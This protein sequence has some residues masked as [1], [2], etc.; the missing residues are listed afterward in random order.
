MKRCATAV[1][2]TLA[3]VSCAT[4]RLPDYSEIS[5]Q[6]TD[7]PFW[8]RVRVSNTLAIQYTVGYQH[9]PVR[10]RAV[11]TSREADAALVAALRQ[12]LEDDSVDVEALRALL[13]EDATR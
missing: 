11:P 3:C 9:N 1:A 12:L 2:L 4:P 6:F 13:R 10:V 8:D 5:L 7:H